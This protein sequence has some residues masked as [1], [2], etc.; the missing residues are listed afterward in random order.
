MNRVIKK[1]F[2]YIPIVVALT[3]F[4]VNISAQNVRIVGVIGEK[5]IVALDRACLR[6]DLDISTDITND[7]LGDPTQVRYF[8]GRFELGVFN[9]HLSGTDLLKITTTNTNM[10][11]E[12][13]AIYTNIKQHCTGN[14]SFNRILVLELFT[15]TSTRGNKSAPILVRHNSLLRSYVAGSEPVIEDEVHNFDLF[16]KDDIRNS[17]LGGLFTTTLTF[18][19]HAS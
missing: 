17:T 14:I 18:E 9:N 19:W 2:I 1:I 15:D 8:V 4:N 5:M 16:V 6:T 12:L 7:S 3:I 11:Q 13:L 10:N